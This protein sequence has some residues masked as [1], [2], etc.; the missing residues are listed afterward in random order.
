MS[1]K[2]NGFENSKRTIEED[3]C[4]VIRWVIDKA[5]NQNEWLLVRHVLNRQIECTFFNCFICNVSGISINKKANAIPVIFVFVSPVEI[6][7]ARVN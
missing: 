4:K 7:I 2:S 3:K 6:N 1:L 5:T